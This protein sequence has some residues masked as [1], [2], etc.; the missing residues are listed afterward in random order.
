MQR[1]RVSVFSSTFNPCAIICSSLLG[2]VIFTT[3]LCS[4][5]PA[6]DLAQAVLASRLLITRP[7]DES[8]LTTL[9][10]N[11]HPLA[12]PVF[13]IGTAPATLPMERMLLVLKRSPEQEAALRKLL[14][15]Q[16]DRASPSYHKWLTPEQFGK[17]F[18]PSDADMQTI[19]AW[20]MSH[21][22]QVGTTKGRGVLEFSGSASQVQEAFHTTIHKYVVNGEQHWANAT[23]PQIPTALTS[24]VA[25][26][27]TLH[28]FP[29]R[30]Q[31]VMAKEKGA[32]TPGKHPQATF[33]DGS[34]GLGPA[35]YA[36]IYN[37]NPVYNPPLSINGNGITIGVIARSDIVA[38][39]FTDFQTLFNFSSN[40]PTSIV[41]GPDPGDIPGDDL[42]ATLDA[43]WSQAIAPGANV[44]I[45]I[46]ASTNTTD[47]VDLSESYIIENNLASV[48][49]ESFSLCEA[50]A[51]DAQ[52]AATASLAEQAAAQGITY[53]V[54][55]G[56]N[57]AEGC[58]DPNTETAATGPISAN[59]L[60]STPF[61]VGVGG[62]VFNENGHDATYWSSTNTATGESAL[63]YIPENVWNDSCT[64]TNC[65]AN[66]N[67]FAGGGGS[68]LG[69]T[70][71][72]GGG[73]TF[74][75]FPIPSWQSGV[76][77]LPPAT[78]PTLRSLPDVSLTAALHDGYVLCFQGSCASNQ[79]YRIGGTS[80]SAPAFAGIMALV[81]HRMMQVEGASGARQGQAD[82]VFYPL[83]ATENLSQCNASSTGIPPAS[84]CVFND[85]TV[86]NNEVPGE[87]GYPSAPY[88]SGPGYDAATG[89]GSVN[90]ANLVTAW[91]SSTSFRA[92]T[93]MLTLNGGTTPIT[94]AHGTPVNVGIT[95]TPSS[96]TGTPTGD[97]ALLASVGGTSGGA[98]SVQQ[99]SLN[100]SGVFTGTTEQLPGGTSYLVTAHYAGN[101]TSTPTGIFAP[102]DSS[103]VMVTVTAENS[104]TTVSNFDQFGSPIAAG[105]SLPFGS[106]VFVRSDVA[107]TTA[108]ST[109]C[110]RPDFIG[111]PTGSV[112]FADLVSLPGP[113]F[114]PVANPSPLNSEGNT[115]IGA[116]VINF[117]DG[118]HSISASYGGDPSFKPSAS[119]TPVTFTIQPGFTLV[120]G[121]TNVTI[122]N[123]GLSGTTTIGIIASTKFTTAITF[124]CSGLPS[125]AA[126][127][128]ASVTGQGPNTVVNTSITVSTMGPHT[129]MLRS[130]QRPYYFAAMLGGLPLAGIFLL[131]APRRRRGALAGLMLVTLLVVVPACGGGGGGG[132]HQTDPGTPAG[133]YTVTVTAASGSL[134]A[135]GAFTL[136]VK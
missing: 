9:K 45:V 106:L 87:A 123:P 65:G 127:S 85:V 4:S 133:T 64:S 8:K 79:V 69:N 101:I 129:V 88:N 95:V 36:V 32:I 39:D 37:I 26:V 71:A 41:N 89:L 132:S 20:L 5:A 97:V 30:P 92:T 62:T 42:E 48:M 116:G 91:A 40:R 110:Q 53:L 124:T 99:F 28:D 34:H 44:D 100:I 76:T 117:D 136:I 68:S 75:G 126:C 43:T 58:D 6:Q 10:G 121:P 86:G 59:L 119:T 98:S 60:A 115:S 83:A 31:Y 49:T 29:K 120:S 16:Q 112:T 128:P 27:L 73:G 130:E 35:D 113:I 107:G 81:D 96:G 50:A 47:G 1:K 14:D 7:V 18:G 52:I 3:L 2:S 23:D 82:Y 11:T 125:E 17:Q 77:G 12:R 78:N 13:D 21:G 131:A 72:H 15:D 118:N 24:A 61:T 105:N 55:T 90:V 56:D 19:T 109:V 102:S 103:A 33:S 25:G 94:V 22:F 114:N 54:A 51:S 46:S 38:S 84:T 108:G 63:S 111:C 80:A 134:S 70:P 122:S 57:G 93:T 104:I 74:T 135:Q 66:A 67:I